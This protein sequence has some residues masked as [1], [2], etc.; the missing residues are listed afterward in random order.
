MDERLAA[1]GECFDVEAGLST[2]KHLSIGR[3]VIKFTKVLQYHF[4]RNSLSHPIG[5]WSRVNCPACAWPCIFI[6]SSCAQCLC[7]D[8]GLQHATVDCSLDGADQ[9]VHET[10][11]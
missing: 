7:R 3:P 11:L 6:A 8:D 4:C 1:I 9:V 2:V 10:K 5:M